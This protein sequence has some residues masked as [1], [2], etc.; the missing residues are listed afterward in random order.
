MMSVMMTETAK[1][2]SFD[3]LDETAHPKT[4][5]PQSHFIMSRGEVLVFTYIIFLV[6]LTLQL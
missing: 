1:I 4:V 2:L 3:R 5:V 6:V